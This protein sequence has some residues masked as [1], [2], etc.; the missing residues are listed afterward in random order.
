MMDYGNYR[1]LKGLKMNVLRNDE[2]FSR[3]DF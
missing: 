3:S 1:N 2:I